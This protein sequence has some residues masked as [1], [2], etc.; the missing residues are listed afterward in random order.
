LVNNGIDLRK[1]SP[2]GETLWAWEHSMTAMR[3]EVGPD[4]SPVLSGFPRVAGRAPP[5]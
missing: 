1:L 2:G 3:A 4:D 5:S